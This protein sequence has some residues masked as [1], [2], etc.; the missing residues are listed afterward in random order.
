M[1]GGQTAAPVSHHRDV[2]GVMFDE[3]LGEYFEQLCILAARG[4]KS[5]PEPKDLQ[6]HT[7]KSRSEGQCVVRSPR[8]TMRW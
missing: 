4:S 5:G 8:M 7:C 1:L 6:Q 3:E 2:I